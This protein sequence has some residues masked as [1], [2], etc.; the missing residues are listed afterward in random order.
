M[1]GV[2]ADGDR[3]RTIEDLSKEELLALFQKI[4]FQTLQISNDKKVA[5]QQAEYYRNERDDLKLKAQQLVLRCKD[6]EEKLRLMTIRED[7][8]Q[9]EIDAL[10]RGRFHDDPSGSSFIRE[11]E[12]KLTLAHDE[13]HKYKSGLDRAI[14]K[15]KELKVLLES[16]TQETEHAK[17]ENL[18]LRKQVEDLTREIS[19]I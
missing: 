2:E 12:T 15:L 1:F 19:K 7:S 8:Y 13:I 16:K 14:P 9:S 17:N 6:L 5:V 3:R 10:T 11:M 18:V 4:K